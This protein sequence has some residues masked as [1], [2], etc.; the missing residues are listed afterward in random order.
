MTVEEFEA[1]WAELIQKWDLSQ[2]ETFIW[3]KSNAHTWFHVTSGIASSP[4]CSQLKE[5][6]DST[7]F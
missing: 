6:R 3:L 1:N 5:A 7:L 4:S 2:N